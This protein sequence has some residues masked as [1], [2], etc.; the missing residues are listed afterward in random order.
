MLHAHWRL[1]LCATLVAC[2]VGGPAVAGPIL[3]DGL[4]PDAYGH[5]DADQCRGCDPNHSLVGLC[6][7]TCS[8]CQDMGRSTYAGDN[9]TT[10]CSQF[11]G[12][13]SA[14]EDAWSRTGQN[15]PVGCFYLTGTCY[16][17]SG[18]NQQ[19]G[20]CTNSCL[21][22]GDPARTVFAG[23]SFPD[24][25][26]NYDGNQGTCETAY[27]LNS[28]G[29]PVTC[30]YAAGECHACNVGE[31]IAEQCTNTC[32][33]CDDASRATFVNGFGDDGCQA[34]FDDQPACESTW[35]LNGLVP[36]PC[37]YTPGTNLNE[38]G[39]RFIQDG[40]ERIGPLVTN[41][42]TLAVC[43][44]CNG[45]TAVTG[46]E[47]GLGESTLAG[48][49]WTNATINDPADIDAFFAGSGTPSV[50]D[51]GIVYMPSQQT[52]GPHFGIGPEQ[53]E[54]V[55]ARAAEL[56]AFVDAGG[57]LFVHN[58]A[59]LERGFEWLG[60]LVPGLTTR[61]AN[62]CRDDLA[63][64][65]PGAA[66]FPSVTDP[67]LQTLNDVSPG[68]FLG[69]PGGLAVLATDACRDVRCKD[70]GHTT[71]LG[72]PGSGFCEELA[73]D[74]NACNAAWYLDVI[75]RAA[76]CSA[77][78][79]STCIGCGR[80]DLGEDGCPDDSCWR[81]D[82][83]ARTN[84][85]GN[86]STPGCEGLGADAT[87]CATA[88]QG[89]GEGINASCFFDGD[90]GFCRACNTENENL[91][92]CTNTCEAA[93]ETRALVLGPG[94]TA[95]PTT[96]TTTTTIPGTCDGPPAPTFESILCRLDA[97]IALVTGS[98]DLGKTKKQLERASAKAREKTALAQDVVDD[99]RKKGK[100]ALKKARR[101]MIS[102]NFRVRSRTGRNVIPQEK[103]DALDALGIP[104]QDDMK[105]L[106]K[107]L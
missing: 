97:L 25:C 46:F 40:F 83:P 30:F 74:A 17:C 47:H 14:C 58:Q 56:K 5:F 67:I 77:E 37:F 32:V 23:N 26:R 35:Y 1:L 34:L 36:A 7:N 21:P 107:S 48:L 64:T 55:N 45:S 86:S 69:D 84:F 88:W 93:P 87:A 78:T 105:T 95:P 68:Y 6:Q 22:C 29:V 24:S 3:V 19:L 20:L 99:E 13:Q 16:P 60:T 92:L 38:G 15:V 49:G 12:N 11:D 2:G 50:D 96:S 71:L 33:A 63:L 70:P 101:K 75:G 76:P 100:N 80:N 61:N 82:E 52:D 57:G 106:F 51:A 31:R 73:G 44:G 53:V 85:T 89:A 41:G 72:G 9:S 81:C 90:A 104:L 28:N 102:F 4:A 27:Q 66:S 10:G 98:D 91:G 42:K 62:T 65:G 59:R 94:Q 54:A 103:R 39:F 43:L 79:P 8:V 18:D